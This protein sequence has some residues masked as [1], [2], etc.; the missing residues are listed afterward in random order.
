MARSDSPSTANPRTLKSD[1]DVSGLRAQVLE[2]IEELEELEREREQKLSWYSPLSLT[3]SEGRAMPQWTKASRKRPSIF[4]KMP[5]TY[6]TLQ[7]K[8]TI[9]HHEAVKAYSVP[10]RI[11]RWAPPRIRT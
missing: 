7:W 1:L 11:I 8:R 2:R 4:L 10:S 9:G 6:S 3:C 5:L